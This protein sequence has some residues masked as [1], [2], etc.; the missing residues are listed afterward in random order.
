MSIR[1]RHLEVFNAIMRTGSVTAAARALSV[2]QPAVSAVLRHAE[3]ALQIRLFERHGGR[4]EPTPEAAALYPEVEAIFG[5]LEAMNRQVRDLAGGRLGAL[6]LA[7]AFPIANGYL[8]QAVAAFAVDRPELRVTLQSLTSPQVIDRVAIRE[9]EL[10]L[11]YETRL[12]PELEGEEL[13]RSAIACVLPATHPL[14]A[15]AEIAMRDLASTPII[16]YLPQTLF[17]TYIDRALD[18]VEAAL[19]VRMQVSVSLTGMM[20]AYHGAGVAL[21]EPFL[22]ASMPIPGLVA[23]PLKPRVEMTTMLVRVKGRPRSIASQAFVEQL[24]RTIRDGQDA[25]ERTYGMRPVRSPPRRHAP[26]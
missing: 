22:L 17:R 11:S 4:L 14:A 26:E 5:R 23:R 16:T 8:A 2:S 6:S 19:D 12:P 25:L 24:K 15:K 18:G 3:S 9:V 10:G 21:V 20:L 7:G 1:L 13:V